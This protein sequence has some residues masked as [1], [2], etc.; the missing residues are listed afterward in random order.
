MVVGV[1]RV[2][3]VSVRPCPVPL[4][5]P[6]AAKG[7]AGERWTRVKATLLVVEGQR[8][9]LMRINQR[10]GPV[11]QPRF[12]AVRRVHVLGEAVRVRSIQHVGLEVAAYAAHTQRRSELNACGSIGF[13]QP[14]R[15]LERKRQHNNKQL[16]R[17]SLQNKQKQKN[18]TL[19]STDWCVKRRERPLTE[20]YAHTAK[21]PIAKTAY[22]PFLGLCHCAGCVAAIKLFNAQYD[23]PSESNAC[24][25]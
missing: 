21:S 3:W 19:F 4:S 25:L 18:K 17:Q 8:R 1:L 14:E 6:A 13:L 22:L 16:S 12:F 5:R 9:A 11:V 23:R 20:N 7:A 10:F 2:R 15:K 24:S